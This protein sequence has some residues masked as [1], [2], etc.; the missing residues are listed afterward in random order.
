M[1]FVVVGLLL[2]ASVMVASFIEEYVLVMAIGAFLA[3]FAAVI[4]YL[5]HRKN[6]K[7]AS[8]KAARLFEE[9]LSL[10]DQ[11]NLP[12]FLAV[13]VTWAENIPYFDNAK[14]EMLSVCDEIAI[15]NSKDNDAFKGYLAK[16]S[17]L[18][19]QE[20]GGLNPE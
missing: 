17:E 11:E 19:E 12:L 7:N 6:K 8:V 14:D 18:E 13:L 9:Y 5:I 3:F 15:V 16:L 4:G 2:I 10:K 1:T 20:S